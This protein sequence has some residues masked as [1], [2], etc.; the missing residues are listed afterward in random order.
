MALFPSSCPSSNT[1]YSPVYYGK[2]V[3]IA[4]GGS[5]AYNLR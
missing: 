3:S 1:G 5:N 4:I 2:F